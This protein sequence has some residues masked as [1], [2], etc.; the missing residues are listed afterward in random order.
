MECIAHN[1]LKAHEKSRNQSKKKEE[2]EKCTLS[3]SLRGQMMTS[4]HFHTHT[5]TYQQ[6][7]SK[8][9]I[10]RDDLKD[11]SV[12]DDLTSKGKMLQMV[13]P[14]NNTVSL[15]QTKWMCVYREGRQNKSIHDLSLVV[16][17]GKFIWMNWVKQPRSVSC[18]CVWFFS[19]FQLSLFVTQ[20]FI[21]SQL[22]CIYI[23]LHFWEGVGG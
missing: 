18:L 11:E 16:W 8:R 2:E 7:S 22:L 20:N 9:W 10:L 6:D 23:Y 15:S 17:F 12:F 1:W 14:R 19:F 21:Y 13:Q 4:C 3:V 5:H